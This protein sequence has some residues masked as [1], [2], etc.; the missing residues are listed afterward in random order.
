MADQTAVILLVICAENPSKPGFVLSGQ[1]F[2]RPEL[3]LTSLGRCGDRRDSPG[4]LCLESTR[5]R[6]CLQWSGIH[7]ARILAD[8]PT[9]RS[10]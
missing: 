1:G 10:G 3:W 8:Q 2:T 9:S 4:N 5:A 7:K 6:F